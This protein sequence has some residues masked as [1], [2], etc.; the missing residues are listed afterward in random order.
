MWSLFSRRTGW[1]LAFLLLGCSSSTVVKSGSGGSGGSGGTGAAG[2]A[3]SGNTCAGDNTFLW[4]RADDKGHCFAM[5]Q[6]TVS[7]AAAESACQLW[8]GHLASVTTQQEQSFVSKFLADSTKSNS[9]S[10]VWIGL[11]RTG[12]TFNWADGQA[13]NFSSF[14]SANAPPANGDGCV[15]M[16]GNVAWQWVFEPDCA[17][18]YNYVCER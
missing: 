5:N 15:L 14:D 3:G 9:I 13:Y 17:H 6:Q 12:S 16:F 8:N 4:S 11:Q 2:G 7:R 1:A 18:P 10:Y